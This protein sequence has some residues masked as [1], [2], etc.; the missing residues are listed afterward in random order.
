MSVNKETQIERGNQEC[1]AN[2]ILTEVEQILSDE[3]YEPSDFMA[4]FVLV[5]CMLDYRAD[6]A[7]LAAENARYKEAL[8]EIAYGIISDGSELAR[9]ALEDE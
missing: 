2:S 7:A 9:Q 1:S 4:S 8:R 5:R 6:Y 3:K